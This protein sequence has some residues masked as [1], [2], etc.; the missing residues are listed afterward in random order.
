MDLLTIKKL[1]TAENSAI[2][3]NP[4]D[5]VAVA[6]VALAPGSRLR[7]AG[8]EIDLRDSVPAG[9]KVA[10]RDIPTGEIVRRYGQ[11]IGRAKG[12][13]RAGDHVHTHNVSFEEVHFEYEYP[14][15]DVPVPAP[16]KTVPTFLGYA[17][18]DGRA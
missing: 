18:E 4:A 12:P 5:N 14:S 16:S 9:H 3:L 7:T 11:V 8:L 17:R 15:G 6:R 13:I 10:L 2:H 1:P